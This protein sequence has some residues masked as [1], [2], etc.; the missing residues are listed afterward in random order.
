MSDLYWNKNFET[1][2]RDELRKHQLRLLKEKVKFC[3]ENT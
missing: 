1:A 2:T 3:Y